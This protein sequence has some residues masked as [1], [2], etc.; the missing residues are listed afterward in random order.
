MCP[1]CGMS[2]PTMAVDDALDAI[3][4]LPARLRVSVEAWPDVTLRTR[5]QENVWSPLEY[6]CHFRDVL[7]SATI[8]LYRTRTEDIPVIEPMFNDLRAARFNYNHRNV[9]A[10][11]DEMADNVKGFLEEARRMPDHG[12]DRRLR[13]LPRETRTARWLVRQTMHE[14]EHHFKDILAAASGQEPRP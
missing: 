10:V 12:W 1:A 14:G 11:L 3:A 9:Q 7:V 4:S 8:R 6:L 13:R 5:P 2:Y